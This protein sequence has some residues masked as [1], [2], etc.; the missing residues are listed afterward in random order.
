MSFKFFLKKKLEGSTLALVLIVV[1]VV[2]AVLVYMMSKIQIQIQQS[3]LERG[4][5][6]AEQQAL[7]AL[8]KLTKEVIEN[9]EA[10]LENTEVALDE[11][12]ICST[13]QNVPPEEQCGEGSIVHITRYTEIVQ[14]FMKNDE[15]I[16]IDMSDDKENV[17]LGISI[18]TGKGNLINNVPDTLI[19]MGYKYDGNTGLKAIGECVINYGG[20]NANVDKPA[21]VGNLRL[22]SG[23]ENGP[24]DTGD[25]YK[26]KYGPKVIELEPAR[27]DVVAFYR[28]KAL[29]AD[30]NSTFPVSVT[31]VIGDA[32][33]S[34]LPAAQVAVLTARVY[35]PDKSETNKKVY[36]E[37][38]RMIWLHPAM[39]ET[40]DWVLF[41]ASNKPIKK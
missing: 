40:F 28:I 8:D 27:G 4:T 3:V 17:N 16:Q 18:F 39:P 38:T 32:G 7:S 14:Y 33:P 5:D 11:I 25:S 37:Y 36:T 22:R 13:S 2:A 34:P 41:N 19:V 23:Y 9:P 30:I 21:C 35:S 15:T 20:D 10:Y 1:A 6:R 31:G 24:K 12:G 26:Q 29:L